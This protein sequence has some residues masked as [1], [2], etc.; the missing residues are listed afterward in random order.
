MS[1]EWQYPK[2]VQTRTGKAYEVRK[3]VWSATSLSEVLIISNFICDGLVFDFI[4]RLNLE[5]Q[6]FMGVGIAILFKHIFHL[7]Q[8][9][10]DVSY[11]LFQCLDEAYV[12]S[13]F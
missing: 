8:F 12:V 13:A 9:F 7:H 3:P 11:F 1:H 6:Q 2:P 10:L 4:C 5:F